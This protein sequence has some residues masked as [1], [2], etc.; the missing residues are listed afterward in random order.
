[1][2][3]L[4]TDPF[5]GT[6]VHVVGT[7]Q[8]RPNLPS[9]GCPFCVGGLEAPEPYDVRWFENRWPAMDGG[10]CE[11]VLYTPVH[12]A[13]FW[14]LGIDGARK[15]IDL[16][17]ERTAALGARDDVDH[18]LVFE[19]RGPEVGAT[20]AHPHGQIYAYDHVPERPARRLDAGWHPDPDPGERVVISHGGWRVW[21]PWAPTFPVELAVAPVARAPD[22]VALGDAERKEM[23]AVLVDV[24]ERLDRLYDRPLPYMMWLNQRPTVR[25]G[26]DDAWFNIE[27]VSPWRSAGVARFIAAAEVACQEYFNPIVPEDLAARLRAL[28]PRR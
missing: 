10:R 20:I 23:A 13:T 25:D 1:V 8:S 21:V 16:W 27:I 18:V 26:H 17:A 12:D 4:R 14:S 3:Q 2:S 5:L 6:R 15:V 22:L 28:A 24:F 9:S 11:V 7:R 19:N